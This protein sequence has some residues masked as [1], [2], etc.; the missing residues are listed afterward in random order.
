MSMEFGPLNFS[1][2]NTQITVIPQAL[3]TTTK[4]RIVTFNLERTA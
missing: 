3:L 2:A 4:A 1:L